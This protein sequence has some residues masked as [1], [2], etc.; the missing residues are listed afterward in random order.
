MSRAKNGL[1]KMPLKILFLDNAMVGRAMG[2]T[3]RLMPALLP[4]SSLRG[5]VHIMAEMIVNEMYTMA[6]G[7]ANAAAR[8]AG[9]TAGDLRN[10]GPMQGDS[11]M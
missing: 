9:R 7:F 2:R 5:I 6:G 10:E 8:R 11:E 3:M 1:E 4:T